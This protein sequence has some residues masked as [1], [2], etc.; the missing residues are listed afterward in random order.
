MYVPATAAQPL[1]VARVVDDERPKAPLVEPARPRRT[2]PPAWLRFWRQIGGTSLSFSLALHAGLI[3]LAG[4]IVFTTSRTERNIDFL[5]G[6]GS[7]KGD[8]ASENLAKQVQARHRRLLTRSQPTHRITT[9]GP[10]TSLAL[11]DVPMDQLEMPSATGLM[12]VSHMRGFGSAGTGLGTTQGFVSLTLFGKLGGEGMPGAFYDLKQTPSRAPT[13]YAGQI[14]SEADYASVINQAAARKF[15]GKALEGY[16]RASQKMS[17]NYLLIPYMAATEG[18]KSFRVEKDVKPSG[19]IVH[20]SAMI[21]PPAPGDYRFVGLFDDALV[22][23]VNGRPVLDGSWYPIVGFGEKKRDASIRQ[24]FGGPIV[25]GTG[26]RHC[27]AG[28]WVRIEGSTR[29]DIVVGERPGGRVGGL[30]LVQAR[31]GRYE[32]RADGSPILPA[33]S[34]TPFTSFDMQRI[35]DYTGKDHAFDVAASTPVFTI[36]KSLFKD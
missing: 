17:F 19:W 26:N 12:S 22:V 16:F 31:N 3:I 32:E 8:A 27:Y 36:S 4:I 7:Q 13:A 15:T 20:Y 14:V 24:D 23:Y 29:I 28:K 10:G 35:E 2:G 9:Q 5:P 6:G 21:Q 33:F 11:P 34:T 1:P 25:P 30:L 18:P